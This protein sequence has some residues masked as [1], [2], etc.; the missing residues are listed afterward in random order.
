M[1]AEGE[2][3]NC[4]TCP[5]RIQQIPGHYYSAPAQ[6]QCPQCGA[7]VLLKDTVGDG[8]PVA[9]Y[10]CSCPRPGGTYTATST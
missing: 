9:Q 4:E 2:G 6:G 1:M 3:P 5:Y 7:P 10:T 8:G